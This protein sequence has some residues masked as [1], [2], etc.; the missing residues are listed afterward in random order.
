MCQLQTHVWCDT[1]FQGITD[2]IYDFGRPV[3][4]L[5]VLPIHHPMIFLYINVFY[6]SKRRVDRYLRK[7]MLCSKHACC[8]NMRVFTE[9]ILQQL[10]RCWTGCY[11][12]WCLSNH[13]CLP[14]HLGEGNVDQENINIDRHSV[15]NHNNIN[16]SEELN[17][18]RH[19]FLD[20]TTS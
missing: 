4:P 18:V 7:A 19:I 12:S 9:I 11:I 1:H 16:L 13:S 5:N 2:N 20:I 8:I 6:P 14:R 3:L 17:H 15:P 10:F